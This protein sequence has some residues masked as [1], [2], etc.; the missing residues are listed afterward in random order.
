MDKTANI[1]LGAFSSVE[2]VVA[3]FWSLTNQDFEGWPAA[4]IATA[5]ADLADGIPEGAARI[6]NM[7]G[8]EVLGD[9]G[10]YFELNVVPRPPAGQQ[11]YISLW[12]EHQEAMGG[13][14]LRLGVEAVARSKS[15]QPGRL[16]YK[17]GAFCTDNPPPRIAAMLQWLLDKS[18]AGQARARKRKQT[19]V[20][21]KRR[22]VQLAKS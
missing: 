15:K 17:L 12:W 2:E 11:H 6:I 8:S 10:D 18:P 3:F 5:L 7:A 14:I 13:D 19:A 21:R 9:V 4:Y 22:R 16:E 1:Q 20:S